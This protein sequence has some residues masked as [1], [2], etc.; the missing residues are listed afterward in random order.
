M[1]FLAFILGFY[2]LAISLVPCS[3]V[4]FSASEHTAQLSVHTHHDDQNH[5]DACSPFCHCNCCGSYAEVL[6]PVSFVFFHA[7]LLKIFQIKDSTIKKE[8]FISSYFGKI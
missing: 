7:P 2:F 8:F 5:K 3:D 4:H 6:N 1:R